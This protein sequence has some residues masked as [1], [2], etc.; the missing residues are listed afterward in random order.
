LHHRQL[1]SDGH[2]LVIPNRFLKAALGTAIGAG[3]VVA[4]AVAAA[5]KAR[6]IVV[7]G[8]ADFLAVDGS[9]VWATNR[10]R[11]E[12]WSTAGKLA[13][14]AM[15]RP[16]GAM[17]I[18]FDSLWVADC[19]DRTLSRIDLGTDR[20]VHVIPTGIANPEGELN[21]V[22]GAGS[23]W[24]ANDDKGL[25]AR[26]DPVT[27]TVVAT[28]AVDP[29]TYYLAFGH[30]SLWAVSAVHRSL[31]KIDP[32]TNRVIARTALGREP[33]FL[34]AGEGAVWVQEQGDG[35]LARIDPET[36]TV[37]GRVKVDGTLQYGDI[38]AGGGKIWLRTTL[39]QTFV[40]I[41]PRT[42]AIKA[43]VGAATGSGAIRYT[44][45]GIWTT[46]HDVHMLSWWQNPRQI[47]E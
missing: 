7:P 2:S 44:P 23:I 29:S 34:V 32:V 11:V 15:T 16:C 45:D 18:A 25:I 37:S 27:S 24:V 3:L 17:A 39:G 20:I 41:D 12:R 28:I 43:R 14:V 40:V 21:V 13:E 31:Q 38:D 36:G 33:G 35:T 10:G 26:I 47:G 6:V 46:S 5:P 9:S 19:Q 1:L 8:S 4:P 22:A 30:R 42:L